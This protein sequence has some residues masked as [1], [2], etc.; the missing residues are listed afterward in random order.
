MISLLL[1]DSVINPVIIII[2]NIN[3]FFKTSPSRFFLTIR[4]KRSVP[5]ST[6]SFPAKMSTYNGYSHAIM[7]K[8]DRE[9]SNNG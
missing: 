5:S 7:L 9:R 8:Y 4:S 6:V 2:I 3:S 1:T